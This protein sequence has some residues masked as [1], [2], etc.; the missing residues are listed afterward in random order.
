MIDRRALRAATL[1]LC[2]ILVSGCATRDRVS[3]SE[4]K[5][6]K[7]PREVRIFNGASGDAVPWDQLVQAAIR[8]DV[9]LIGE[10][11]GHPLGLAAA[12]AL[13]ADALAKSPDAA[14]CMEFLERDEQSR[15]DDYLTGVVDEQR[16]KTRTGRTDSNYPPGHREMIEAARAVHRPVIAANAPRA[17]VSLAR[18]EGYER[19]ATLTS[20]QQRLVRIPDNLPQGRY[21]KDFDALMSGGESHG[22][23]TSKQGDERSQMDAMFRSQSLWDWTMAD[24]VA[25]TINSGNH[26]VFL[27]VG[28]FH[29]D[30]DGG[31]PQ[32]LDALRPSAKRIVVSMV[33][34][35][36]DTLR[37]DDRERGS[38]VV[39]VGPSE[40]KE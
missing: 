17:L 30:F 18:K 25:R 20:E 39:Y 21:R 16:F 40:M 11:H 32:A 9:V 4:S 34:D 10:N 26:P 7:P 31:L 1:A 28:H 33:D 15:L 22:D 38:Y 36:S 2:S 37:A 3:T 6:I 14:L 35:W 24:S 12:A 19:F 23:P 29:V 13:W 8:S 5:P 27:V